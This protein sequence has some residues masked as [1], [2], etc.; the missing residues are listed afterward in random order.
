VC[1]RASATEGPV[2]GTALHIGTAGEAAIV[3]LTISA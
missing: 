3:F 1:K 2:V